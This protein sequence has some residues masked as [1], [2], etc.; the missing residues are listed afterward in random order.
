MIM[1]FSTSIESQS[2]AAVGQVLNLVLRDGEPVVVVDSPPGAGKTALVETLVATAVL[3]FGLRVAVVTPRAEQSNDLLRRLTRDYEPMTM[4]LLKAREREIPEDITILPELNITSSADDLIEFNGPGVTIGTAAKMFLSVP[5]LGGEKFDILICDEAYQLAY[6]DFIPMFELANQIVLVGD[7]G[8][9]LPLIQINT[10]L[11]E[12]ASYR[13]HWPVPKETLRRFPSIPVVKLPASRR[14]PQDTVE[15]IQ[16]SFYPELPFSSIAGAE[17]RI[18]VGANGCDDPIDKAIDLLSNGETIV[19]LLLPTADLLPVG[20][21]EELTSLIADITQRLT[22]RNI[23]W[24]EQRTLELRD[25]GCVDPHVASG[26]SIRRKLQQRGIPTDEVMVDTPE[27]WQGLERP[28]MIVKHP[29][30]SQNRFDQFNLEPGRF[31]VMLSRH[32]LGCIIVGR[33]GI[34]EALERHQHDCGSR[35]LGAENNEWI[36][37]RA[38]S[39]I[40]AEMERRRRLIRIS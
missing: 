4:Q 21:D 23:Q 5:Q 15:I 22:T 36:G 27:I 18:Q 29:L 25:I 14:L 34:G 8:Q 30:S 13:V 1:A 19:G 2:R 32:Q 10:S 11:F 35:A 31:C 33:D 12:A 17:R 6:K 39:S 3:G 38:H 37:W 7:P 9:L 28:I 24:S 40:W 26:A 20:I 16:P